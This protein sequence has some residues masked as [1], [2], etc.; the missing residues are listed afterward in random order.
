MK[1]AHELLRIWQQPY[2]GKASDNQ[3][4]HS[5]LADIDI[6][7]DDR[8]WVSQTKAAN[9]PMQY[10]AGCCETVGAKKYPRDYDR[11]KGRHAGRVHTRQA[12]PPRLPSHPCTERVGAMVDH[13]INAMKRSP[14]DESPPCTMPEPAEQ[15]GDEEINITPCLS[16]TITAKRYIEILAKKCR[17]RHVPA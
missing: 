13:E 17:Q 8:H 16:L 15:H 12:E 14:N 4:T 3:Q 1:A 6:R 9:H 7:K 2:R 10:G 11:Q 5:N